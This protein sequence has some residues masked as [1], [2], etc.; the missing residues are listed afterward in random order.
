MVRQRNYNHNILIYAQLTVNCEWSTWEDSSLCSTTCGLG[1]RIS[2]RQ[3]VQEAKFG[4]DRC[5]GAKERYRDCYDKPCPGKLKEMTSWPNGEG[6]I[7]FILH[8]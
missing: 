4:G 3:V 5:I 6:S 1:V 2:S 7:K 8:L